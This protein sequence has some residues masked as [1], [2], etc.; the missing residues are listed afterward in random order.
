RRSDV[1]KDTVECAKGRLSTNGQ[2]SFGRPQTF[3]NSPEGFGQLVDWAGREEKETVFVMEATGVYYETLA[4]WLDGRG[5]KLS[6]LLPG[7]VK[8]YGRSPNVTTKTDGDAA[9]LLRRMGR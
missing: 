5:R 9:Q 3:P 7:K 1:G 6:V 4:Y 2:F 8:H